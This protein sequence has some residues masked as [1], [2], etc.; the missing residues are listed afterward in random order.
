MSKDKEIEIKLLFKN[1]KA[2]INKL[3]PHIK[4][5]SKINIHDRYYGYD[6]FD[7]SNVNNLVRIRTINKKKSELTFKSKAKDMKNVWHRTELNTWIGSPEKME[8]ILLNLGLNKISEYKSEKEF[9][10]YKKQEIVFAKFTIPARLNF[11][12][13]EG[14]SKKEIKKTVKLLG[15]NIKEVGEEIFEVFDRVRKKQKS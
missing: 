9:W 2:I 10:D 4:L 3:K 7:M 11:M 14:N 12:E 1:K 15:N 8:K 13:I 6:N 5:K